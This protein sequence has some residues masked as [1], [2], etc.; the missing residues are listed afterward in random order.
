VNAVLVT[1]G[2]GF[3]GCHFVRHCLAR[4]DR[5]VVV[6]DKLTYAGHLENLDDVR[7]HP[8]LVFHQGDIA[9][10]HLVGQLLTEHRVQWV[11]HLAAESHV[12]RSAD[13]PAPFVQ[14]NVV[15]TFQLLEACLGYWQ[16][17]AG[18]LQQSFRLVHVSTDEVYGSLQADG[19]FDES[20]CYAPSSP[21][22]ASKAA[23]DHFAGAYYQT[24]GL[25]AIVVNSTNNYG[26][27]QLPEKLIPL[28]IQRALQGQDLPIY[29]DGLQV[30]DWLHVADHVQGIWHAL[31]RGQP[32]QSYLFGGHCERTNLE[33]VRAVCHELA[34]RASD[35]PAASAGQRISH[36]ADR[37]GHDRRYAVNTAKAE[38]QLDWAP[39]RSLDRD[40]GPVV[41]WYLDNQAWVH[42]VLDDA[43]G[44][45][46]AGLSRKRSE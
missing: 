5:P 34:R 10:Q 29:G 25:P 22:A 18:H 38:R 3:I 43:G 46:R 19:R 15:G 45:Q 1:G 8:R 21:Y 11:V 42:R 24:Y 14:T 17:A 35:S 6:L 2:A 26:P 31:E 9:D 23:G 16:S 36:V 30:R 33:L 41:Q 37:L 20:A 13:Q 27:Y 7:H 28:M 32:G 40:L 39:Q 12:D 44:G 4:D